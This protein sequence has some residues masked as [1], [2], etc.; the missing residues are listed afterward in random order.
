MA[1]PLHGA[2]VLRAVVA[3]GFAMFAGCVF[4]PSLSVDT[5]DAGANSA[6]A[7]VSVRADLVEFPQFSTLVFEKGNGA[8][9]LNVT[10]HD[11]DLDDTLYVKIFV[12]YNRPD[13]T[14]ARSQCETAGKTVERT[15]SAP[16]QAVCTTADIG[17]NPLP[18]MQV[19]VSDADV[20]PNI[21]PP[22]QGLPPGRLSTSLT[23]FLRCQDPSL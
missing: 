1:R 16:M 20:E 6:P 8:G 3:L 4:P 5:T 13:P 14:P 2:G 17:A 10:L 18:V 7:I 11:T 21:Q 19:F 12:N 22:F 23:F 15:C 9:Q